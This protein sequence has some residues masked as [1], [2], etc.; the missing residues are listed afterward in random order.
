[1]REGGPDQ[2]VED[3]AGRLGV[4]KPVLY[5]TFGGRAGVAE[6]MSVELASRMQTSVVAQLGPVLEDGTYDVT[7]DRVV[8]LIVQ[9]LLA[10]V[11]KEPEIYAFIVTSIRGERRGVL[12]NALAGVVSEHIHPIIEAATPSLSADAQ[13]VLTHGI[14]GLALATLE[15]W[16]ATGS[17]PRET[18]V[19][20]LTTIIVAG[21]HA[22]DVESPDVTTG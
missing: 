4:S 6:A 11:E 21:L 17:L 1:V 3:L 18:V 13:S 10:L 9:G 7:V 22:I 16:Q 2:S 12:D 19:G 14:Y 5:A 15:S 20:M 8:E